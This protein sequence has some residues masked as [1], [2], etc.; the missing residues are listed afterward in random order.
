LFHHLEEQYYTET[1]MFLKEK[2]LQENSE[3]DKAAVQPVRRIRSIAQ[4]W[5]VSPQG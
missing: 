4:L 1:G 2:S 3:D 5:G